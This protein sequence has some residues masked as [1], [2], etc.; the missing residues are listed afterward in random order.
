MA[1]I[2]KWGNSLALRIPKAIAEELQL[3]EGSPISIETTEGKI[4]ITPKKQRKKYTLEELL[5]GMTE[6][7]FHP[8]IDTGLPVGGEE[9]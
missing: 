8:E 5:E 3:N 9:W 4:L 7:K 6:D 1:V 2:S